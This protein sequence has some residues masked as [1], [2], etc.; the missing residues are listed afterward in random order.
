MAWSAG[1]PARTLKIS[2]LSGMRAGTPALH[3]GN[4]Q[5]LN[6]DLRKQLEN[7]VIA[8]RRTAEKGAEKALRQLTVGDRDVGAYL[9]N[10]QRKLRNRLRAHGRQL[11]DRQDAH[12]GQDSKR[13]KEE[14]AYEHWHRMLF[15]RFL[16]E[17]DL[18]IEP[19]SG[20]PI[21]L[22]ECRELAR[23]QGLDWLALASDF[24]VRML[25]QIFR[26]GDPVLE[27]TLPPETRHELEALLKSLPRDV[28]LADE[29]LGWVY[30]FWQTE[31]KDRVNKSELAIGAAELPAVTQLFTEDYMVLFLLHNTLGAWWAGKVL[32]K[33][34][35]VATGATSEAELREACSINGIDWTYLR[36]V[37]D[38]NGPWR[39]AAGTFDGW[40]RSAREITV[41]DPCTGSGHFLVFALPIVVALRMEDENLPREQAIAVVLRDNLFGLELDNR[42]TQIAAF[43]LALTAWR[44]AAYRP[45]PRLNIA[46]SG[47]GINA[48]QE[49]WLKLAGKDERIRETMRTL[50]RLFQQ[51][52]ELG[53]LIDPKRVGG[54]LFAAQFEQVRPLLERALA[55][56]QA[57]ETATELAV[58]A[59]GLVQA[60]PI[61]AGEFTLVGTNVP[62]LG[63]G[64]HDDELK[65]FCDRFHPQAKADLATCFVQR[66]L[67]FCGAGGTAALVTMQ[68]WL[69]LPTFKSLR[70][71]LLQEAR[72]QFVAR[73]GARAFETITGEVVNVALLSLTR[74]LPPPSHKLLGINASDRTNPIEK[75]EDLRTGVFIV[76]TQAGMLNNPDFRVI[77]TNQN[78]AGSR[79]MSHYARSFQGIKTGDDGSLKRCFWEMPG[80]TERW[81]WFLTTVDR[82]VEYGGREFILRWDD[83]GADIARLQGQAAWGKR[84]IAVSLMSELRCS[85]YAGEVFDSN[86]AAVIPQ[87]DSLWLPLWA[88][89]SSSQFDTDVKTIEPG[90]KANS[91]SPTKVCFDVEYWAQA[92]A[93]QHPH[94]LPK[95]HSDH[96]T[97]WLFCGHP[98]GA[99]QA[100]QVAVARL[101]GYRWPRQTGS[102]FFDCPALGPDGLESHAGI[103]GIVCLNSIKGEAP[104]ADRLRALLADACL[105][106]WSAAKQA[107]LL[108]HASYSGKSLE[109]WL[110]DAFF[111]QHC[112]LFHNRP[113][114]WQVWDG[115]NDGFH[116]L[117][118]YHKLAAPNGE[119][120]RTIEKLIY[121]YL[122]DWIDRQRADQ[123][124]GVEGAD[125]RL[126]AAQHL[127]TELKRI[128]DGEKPHDIF[129]RWKPLREQPIGWEPDINDG[130]RVNMRPFMTAR[131]LGAR[132]KNACILRV[133]P[134][135][136]WEKDRG[137]EPHRPK[138]DYPWF[139]SWDEATED[140]AGGREFDGNR[141]ND[142]HYSL[143][144][145]R[146]ARDR[147][148]ARAQEQRA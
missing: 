148:A 44:M 70:K 94:G 73:L 137:K 39:P 63:R 74:T 118:N 98:N 13:L 62:Y 79:R 109:A 126:A 87:E 17:S 52:P 43:N 82:T 92:A 42:C 144:F 68:A 83:G 50:Y 58:A 3:Q 20:M 127:Q 136:K 9:S 131:P 133:T 113:F 5:T 125:A 2:V 130:V 115:R 72:W 104:A 10:E 38:E 11:G 65:E 132:A 138:E 16:A 34:P 97:Q 66:C 71:R 106:E 19:E 67:D 56:E 78:K 112:A 111:E 95:P 120:R 24:A 116:A 110:R 117:V 4:M 102:S 14:C 143:A 145:K 121:S 45:L 40:P 140:F 139:W 89:C 27:V 88:Y 22:D 7:T 123:K 12:G 55:A 26:A 77:F 41:L 134:K 28:F 18:L 84:G 48:K 108:V 35:E 91:A 61:L 80:Q 101:V 81:E 147:H 76:E 93:T 6:R 103:D 21:T 1:V 128:L 90:L 64:K 57:D 114:I 47:L 135:I 53:S 8:A 36:F 129:V 96:P 59:Q 49:D 31:E 146:K 60:A 75:S 85:L 100:L 142:L 99:E 124:Q 105:G 122:G 107:E 30:Q 23:E 86:V 51:A 141:W 54:N 15:A 25:P 32:G 46:C 119:G 37:R 29:S 33:Q 69:F